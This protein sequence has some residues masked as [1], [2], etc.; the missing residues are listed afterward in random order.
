MLYATLYLLCFIYT[1]L[2]YIHYIL[3]Y[4]RYIVYVY[5][6]IVTFIYDN[7]L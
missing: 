6:I 2:N 4:L 5:D 1:V 3:P 7:I